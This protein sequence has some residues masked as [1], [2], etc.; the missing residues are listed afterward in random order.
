MSRKG[1]ITTTG[2]MNR[3]DKKEEG[4]V[5]AADLIARQPVGSQRTEQSAPERL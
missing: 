2:G 3:C 5:V 4:Q 1:K